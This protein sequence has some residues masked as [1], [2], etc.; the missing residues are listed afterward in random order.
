[1]DKELRDWDELGV[2]K[3]GTSI[4]KAAADLYMT[5]PA[6]TR[7]IQ[8]IE[9]YYGLTLFDRINKRLSATEVN[10]SPSSGQ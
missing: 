1:M 2:L 3:L 6:V 10:C 8:E 7:A 9:A 4:T 5:Q